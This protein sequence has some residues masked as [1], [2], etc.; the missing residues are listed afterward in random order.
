[1]KGQTELPDR[2]APF[3]SVLKL[4]E[5]SPQL[6]YVSLVSKYCLHFLYKLDISKLNRTICLTLNKIKRV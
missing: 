1:M 3:L 6:D 4:Y 5:I 2:S